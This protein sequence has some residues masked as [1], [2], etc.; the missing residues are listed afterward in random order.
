MIRTTS[1]NTWLSLA[2]PAEDE[3]SCFMD[4]GQEA[5]IKPKDRKNGLGSLLAL[6]LLTRR[7]DIKGGGIQK[8][9]GLWQR[10]KPPFLKTY[11]R[12]KLTVSKSY[13]FNFA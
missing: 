7:R 6:L 8:I 2:A 5:Q 10:A 9:G 11:K 1:Y 12:M 3:I 13:I 4:Q